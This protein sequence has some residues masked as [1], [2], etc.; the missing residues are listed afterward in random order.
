MLM[1][2]TMR[3]L[4]AALVCSFCC[5]YSTELLAQKTELNGTVKD[6]EGKPVASASVV[7]S[8]T[9][10]GTNTGADGTF[11]LSLPAGK[12]NLDISSVGFKSKN[13]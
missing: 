10:K 4:M 2:K 5:L 6:A 8:S 9:G 7:I 3:L 1:M 12:I 13:V 11:T